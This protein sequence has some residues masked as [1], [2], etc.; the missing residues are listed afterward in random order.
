[1]E[2]KQIKQSKFIG[3]FNEGAKVLILTSIDNYI[4]TYL[5]GN[6]I[7]KR[8]FSCI[9]KKEDIE[10]LEIDS[11]IVSVELNRTLRTM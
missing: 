7:T 10:K 11:N 3:E 5:D 1:M 8:I 2:K 4:P 6:K 9:L